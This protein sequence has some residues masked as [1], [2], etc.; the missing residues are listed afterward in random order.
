MRVLS[1]KLSQSIRE[2]DKIKVEHEDLDG[3]ED[4]G[5]VGENQRFELEDQGFIIRNGLPM[6]EH[7]EDHQGAGEGFQDAANFAD[8]GVRMNEPVD[9]PVHPDGSG[10]I[11]NTQLGSSSLCF[12]PVQT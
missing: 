11:R 7:R 10:R 12:V 5:V 3:R 1:D 4:D 9:K 8:V 2:F 6:T